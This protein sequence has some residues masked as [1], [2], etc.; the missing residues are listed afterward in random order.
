MGANPAQLVKAIK[1][2]EE[3]DGPSVIIAYTPCSSHGICAGMQKVQDEMKRAVDA[4]YWTLYRYDPRL[5]HPFQL[6]S[7]EPTM[8]YEDFLDGEVRYNSLKR[9]FP[10][11]AEKFFSQAARD[12][13]ERYDSF[14]EG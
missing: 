2:A 11:N 7:K 9:T 12:A 10:E 3:Y 6:D 8:P 1:E 13:A 5:E 4:G 14:K